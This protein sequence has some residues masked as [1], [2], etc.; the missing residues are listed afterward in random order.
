MHIILGF[1]WLGFCALHSLLA[2]PK[3][4]KIAERLLRQQFK[5]YRLYYSLFAFISLVSILLFLLN[6]PSVFLY[7]KTLLSNISGSV[8]GLG[9]LTVMFI[10]I[11]KYFTRLSGIKSLFLNENPSNELII[12]GIHK[13][14]RHPLYAGT[15]LFIWGLWLL[16]PLLSLLITNLIITIYTIIG[17]RWEEQK[18]EAEFG[19][20]YQQYKLKVPKLIPFLKLKAVFRYHT[21]NRQG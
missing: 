17:I 18:L 6:T 16:F 20:R 2:S 13:Y 1:L 14:L 15:F 4:K 5:F 3:V 11:R 7:K 9:G 12:T 19:E 21:K 10:C 8:I